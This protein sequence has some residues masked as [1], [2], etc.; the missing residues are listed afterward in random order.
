MQEAIC[1]I[2]LKTE[3]TR[4][5]VC[6]YR[7]KAAVKA[8]NDMEDDLSI[9]TPNEVI[10]LDMKNIKICTM[11]SV[12]AMNLQNVCISIAYKTGIITNIFVTEEI[13]KAV[14]REWSKKDKKAKYIR[15][16][17]DE[18]MLLLKIDGVEYMSSHSIRFKESAEV[19]P[20]LPDLKALFDKQR[21]KNPYSRKVPT[22][23][24]GQAYPRKPMMVF[25]GEKEHP[26]AIDVHGNPVKGETLIVTIDK[27]SKKT[28][29]LSDIA[30]KSPD[31][32]TPNLPIKGK[33][34]NPYKLPTNTFSRK[35]Y[36]VSDA[37]MSE[38][39]N[40]SRNEEVPDASE[41]LMGKPIPTKPKKETVVPT[42]KDLI[43]INCTC[44]NR[45]FGAVP[46]GAK[47]H[48]CPKCGKMLTRDPLAEKARTSDHK[49]AVIFTNYYIPCS[50]EM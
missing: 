15:I 47:R 25:K 10:H 29:H 2:I 31:N 39:I 49:E 18:S 19:V 45:L 16:F 11:T 44:G 20:A 23:K 17:D 7:I 8:M 1:E 48:S 34:V 14:T 33:T 46:N 13:A 22:E 3:K 43:Q 28:I 27:D 42:G 21:P 4:K 41:K 9:H 36:G 40:K 26:K 5:F 38:T 35:E 24:G 32:P 6:D 37:K 50:L 30:K 12:P